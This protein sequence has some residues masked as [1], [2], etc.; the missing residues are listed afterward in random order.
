MQR[1][2][3]PATNVDIAMNLGVPDNPDDRR[4]TMVADGGEESYSDLSPFV[5]L[6]KNRGRVKILDVLLRRPNSELTAEQLSDLADI[7]VSTISRNRGALENL[8]IVRSREREGVTYYSLNADNEVVRLL[9]EF[10]IELIDHFD[11][12]LSNTD[13]AGTTL[14]EL[15]RKKAEE[16]SSQDDNGRDDDGTTDDQ[17]RSAALA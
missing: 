15:L 13:N 2:T 10:H 12:I 9:G 8:E 17:L 1:H 6:L 14:I 16:S 11:H 3:I 4:Q 5:R 7:S